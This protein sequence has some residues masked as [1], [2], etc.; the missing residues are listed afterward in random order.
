MS[1]RTS[2]VGLLKVLKNAGT[3]FTV[4]LTKCCTSNN[5]DRAWTCKQIRAKYS[6]TS[7]MQ[8]Q[9]IEL[10]SNSAFFVSNGPFYWYGGHIET[11]LE[12]ANKSVLNIALLHL[13]KFRL[14]N[15]FRTRLFSFPMDLFTDTAAILNKFDLRSII[16]CPGGMSTFRLYF[17]ALF[18]TFFLRIRL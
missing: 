2:S 1:L 17:R 10:F 5:K 11:V 12:R 15:S 13:C 18:G 4:F 14:L 6:S 16:G 7:F 3:N 8:I 9:T